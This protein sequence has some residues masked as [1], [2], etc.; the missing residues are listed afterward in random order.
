MAR[1]KEIQ[2]VLSSNPN[3]FLV[4]L[5]RELRA[6]FAEI[7]KLEEEF[8]ALK[9]QITWLVKGDRNIGFYHTLAL[10]Q[11]R[12]NRI[13][14]IKDQVGNWIHEEREIVGYIR[15]CYANL[16]SSSHSHSVL[17][18]WNPPPFWQ[19]QISEKDSKKLVETISYEEIAT[20]LW[21]L[22]P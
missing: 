13:S 19:A 15:Q 5:E 20:G 10:V 3:S 22:K 18:S 11:R 7:S 17:S 1:L 8:W 12:R 9:S 6:E 14:C 4:N 16:Y 21:S 2:V